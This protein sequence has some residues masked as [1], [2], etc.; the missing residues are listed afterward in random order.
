MI[1]KTTYFLPPGWREI[2]KASLMVKQA[3]FMLKLTVFI[4]LATVWQV[5]ANGFP[6]PKNMLENS[7]TSTANFM[8]INGTVTDESGKPLSSVSVII[9]GTKVGTSTDN[10][11]KFSLDA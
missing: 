4:L 8:P 3:M 9:K 10:N 11:G 2:T 5:S 1:L 7:V 6:H